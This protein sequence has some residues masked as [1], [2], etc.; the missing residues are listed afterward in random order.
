MFT[1]EIGLNTNKCNGC[2][3][4]C[5]VSAFYYAKHNTGYLPVIDNKIKTYYIDSQGNQKYLDITTARGGGGIRFNHDFTQIAISS[6]LTTIS[7]YDISYSSDNT[8]TLTER[9]RITHGMGKNINDIA[10]T[11]PD[12]IVKISLV[13]FFIVVSLLII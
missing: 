3:K 6:S 13:T 5:V 9:I 11:T 7:I 2:N 12:T 1:Q 4:H 10:N 8:P